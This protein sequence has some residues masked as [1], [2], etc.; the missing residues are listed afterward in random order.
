MEPIESSLYAKIVSCKTEL[1]FIGASVIILG[2]S[3]IMILPLFGARDK[4]PGIK[5][6]DMR[7]DTKGPLKIYVDVSGA[8][9]RPGIYNVPSQSHVSDAIE[10]AGGLIPDADSAYIAKY[11]NLAKT[12]QNEEKIYI[13]LKTEAPASASDSEHIPININT[14]SLEELTSLPRIGET[15][16]QKIIDHRPYTSVDQLLNQKVVSAT[17]FNTLK[18]LIQIY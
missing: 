1:A 4:R 18:P 15:T 7:T 12:V 16:A 17:L 9:R 8:V 6:R 10:I 14:A 2:I 13:P 3:L 5:I 11:I